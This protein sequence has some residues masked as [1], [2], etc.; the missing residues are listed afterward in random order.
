MDYPTVRRIVSCEIEPLIPQVVA[1]Y[2]ATENRH[3]VD[4]PR[5]EIVYDDARHYLLTTRENFDIITSDPIHP[6]VKG[7]AA[8]YTREYFDL[9]RKHLNAGG[10]VSQWVPLYSTTMEAVKSELAT[11]F[12]AFPGGTVWSNSRVGKG[13]DIVL[14]GG[15]SIEPIRVDEVNERLKSGDY[16]NAAKSLLEV[17]FGAAAD[18][19]ATYLTRAA[20]LSGWLEGAEINRDLNFRLQYLAGLGLNAAQEVQIYDSL[21]KYSTVPQQLFAGSPELISRLRSR[22][23]PRAL[24]LKQVT[25]ISNTLASGPSRNIAITSAKGDE[26]GLEYAGQ[27]GQA[28]TAGGWHVALRQSVFSSPVVGLHI[29]VG[30]RPQPPEANELFRALRVAGLDVVGSFDRSVP[31]SVLLAV[32]AE[33]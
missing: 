33:E 23:A 28:I 14:L 24:T 30:I 1:K 22:Q 5:V 26:E 31:D 8:L 19:L 18:L 6:W 15:E 21:V 20:D 16:A 11:F 2:F 9:V 27:L 10:I 12:E 25:A 29:L 4:D 3:V 7:S 13:Y 17:G 32:G